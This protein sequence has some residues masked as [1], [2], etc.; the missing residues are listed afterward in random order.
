MKGN[1]RITFC[2]DKGNFNG[3]MEIH[4][5]VQYLMGKGMGM[6]SFIVQLINLI[7]KDLGA[8]ELKM[9]KEL[10][11]FQMEGFIKVIL[12]MD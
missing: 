8:K 1:L 2:L 5:L 3:P 11:V 7:I 10:S 12:R 9:G 4:I 6:D